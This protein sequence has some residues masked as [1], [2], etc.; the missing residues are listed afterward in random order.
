MD[1]EGEDRIDWA[2]R[3]RVAYGRGL[4]PPSPPLPA[5]RRRLEWRDG[6]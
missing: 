2:V 5:P 1:G 6:C 4:S 3:V